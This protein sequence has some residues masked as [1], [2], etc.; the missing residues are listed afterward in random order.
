MRLTV[1]SPSL[2]FYGTHR[3][4]PC[5]IPN[6][7]E[8][9]ADNA[10]APMGDELSLPRT[11][12]FLLRKRAGEHDESTYMVPGKAPDEVVSGWSVNLRVCMR[13]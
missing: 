8:R 3:P 7:D 9:F 11:E 5:T 4:V 13:V 6:L 1:A 2:K 10:E 12:E